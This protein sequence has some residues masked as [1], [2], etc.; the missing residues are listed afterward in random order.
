MKIVAL[1]TSAVTESCVNGFI[2]AGHDILCLVSEPEF[3][4]PVNSIK[5]SK[6]ANKINSEYYETEDINTPEACR[7]LASLE[8]DIIFSTWPR[9]IHKCILDIPKYCVIGTHPTALPFN[10]GRHPLHWLI[11]L[12]IK[13]SITSASDFI[14][15][16]TAFLNLDVLNQ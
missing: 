10:R 7:Y 8:P 6:V 13:N 1:G 12:G 5:I 2:H 14:L 4:Y 16:S 3:M 11:V 15:I 9:L